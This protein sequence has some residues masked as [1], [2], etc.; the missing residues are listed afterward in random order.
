LELLRVAVSDLGAI[1]PL[2]VPV[3]R[4][5]RSTWLPFFEAYF[6]NF[7]EGTEFDVDE[8]RTIVIDGT[9][10]DDRP[11]DAHDV[12]ATY[13]LASDPSDRVRAP[14]NG[15]E[16]VEILRYRHSVLMAG[17]P[18]KHPGDFKQT[19]NFAGG[20]QFVEPAL[21]AGT[22]IAGFDEM[23]GLV[24][25]FARAVAMMILVTEVHPFDDG[26][27][28]VARLMANSELSRAGQ[29]RIIIPTVYRN[30]YLAGL[31][32]VSNARVGAARSLHSIMEFAQ[33]WVTAV[34]WG[35]YDDAR[36]QMEQT[37]AFTDPTYA[38]S[39]EIRL[40]LPK[41]PGTS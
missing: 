9:G 35:D 19:M 30:N 20:Y 33:R 37:N 5:Q 8:A 25:P 31:R 10:P 38:D 1:A 12:T 28:R 11:A 22:L 32:A 18:D 16:L 39:Q 6:S 3:V 36:L 24:D 40:E 14:T 26:N 17:R 13:L 2:P 29:M 41:S 4:E 27:G 21:V 15:D 23:A 7:I 34:D